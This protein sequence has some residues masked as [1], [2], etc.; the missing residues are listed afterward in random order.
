MIALGG[1]TVR[2]GDRTVLDRLSLRVAQ[3]EAVGMV[4]A[5]GSGKSTV[6][7]VLAG[8]HRDW[9]G[10]AEVMGRSVRG[11]SP[12]D[13]G[14]DLQ[15]VFQDPYGSLHPRHRV[16]RALREPIDNHRLDERER[17]TIAALAEVGLAAEHRFRYPH[18]LSGGQRQRVAIARALI[19]AP[20]V[21]LLDEPTSALDL[22]AQAAI[23]DL[24]ERVR[25][26]RGM[27]L[28]LV[29][30]DLAVVARLCDRVVVI[31]GGGIVEELA[32]TD[33]RSGAARHPYTRE[34]IA[35]S[36]P[37]RRGASS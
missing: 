19:L 27:S 14:R 18:E 25:R 20:R 28:L 2:F 37:Y 31:D 13:L 15:M 5:S 17:R 3:G 24:L 9:S 34:L 16:A 21:L 30:H 36:R 33:L 35:A 26:E 4:G 7:R 11:R 6:L 8:L 22:P 10:T 1:L 23:L 29:S 32:V 12:R